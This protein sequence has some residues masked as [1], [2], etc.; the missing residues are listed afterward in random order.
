MLRLTRSIAS[1]NTMSMTLRPMYECMRKVS[2]QQQ[3]HEMHE[4]EEL[5]KQEM[6]DFTREFLDKRIKITQFQRLLLAAGSSVTALLDPA[7]QDMIACL[8]ETTGEDSLKKML[9]VMQS[10]A[11]GQ[12]I[13]SQKPRINTKTVDLNELQNLP[14]D[15]FGFQYFKF[16]EVNVSFIFT[17]S[18]E[19]HII[20]FIYFL[21]RNNSKLRRTHDLMYVLWMIHSWPTL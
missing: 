3:Q 6:D 16:L 11:E 19:M 15:T 2:S 5:P 1:L 12:E 18:I 21:F 14:E 7:R 10:T 17:H 9:K 20:F 4:D 13:L 8:G